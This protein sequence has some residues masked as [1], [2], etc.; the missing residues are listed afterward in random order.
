M[1]RATLRKT[2][3]FTV[4]ELMVIVVV[5]GILA[6][7]AIPEYAS[8]RK[9]GF[10][11]AVRTDIRN[12]AIAQEA[13]FAAHAKYQDAAPATAANLP[14]FAPSDR[15]LISVAVTGS[16]QFMV[17]GTHTNCGATTWSYDNISGAITDATC[18]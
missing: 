9:Q 10:R 11:A 4:I 18:P 2:S 15:V 8:Y 3:G 14:G 17:T 6:L 12:A 7:I 1:N 13:Y 16:N 5:I